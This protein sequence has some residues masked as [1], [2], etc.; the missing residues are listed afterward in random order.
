[1]SL[2]PLDQFRYLSLLKCPLVNIENEE[3]HASID[4]PLNFKDHYTYNLSMVI[5]KEPIFV[6]L[7]I[8]A[9]AVGRP[10]FAMIT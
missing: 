5:R 2:H 10:L 1:M 8:Q 3:L 7:F 4:F 9:K 6:R